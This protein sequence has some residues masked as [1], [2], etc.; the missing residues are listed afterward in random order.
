[1][2]GYF[3]L[4]IIHKILTWTTGSFH[5]HI[6]DL[7]ACEY[8]CKLQH[9]II[10]SSK[11]FCSVSTEF[12]SWEISELAHSLAHSSHPSLWWPHMIVLNFG[13]SGASA[14]TLYY[15]LS[16]DW[17]LFFVSLIVCVCVCVCVCRL[18]RR[19]Q[20]E[21]T[22]RCDPRLH[23]FSITNQCWTSTTSTNQQQVM[24]FPTFFAP[25][26]FFLNYCLCLNHGLNLSF[27][28]GQLIKWQ[29]HYFLLQI[30]EMCNFCHLTLRLAMGAML[31]VVR[32]RGT[33]QKWLFSSLQ[34]R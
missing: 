9:I 33:G 28:W 13:F 26:A 10:A 7:Y 20:G 4:S 14:L 30:T 19:T 12:D 2:L 32:L 5:V 27:I 8:T 34:R 11:G 25:D 3:V 21:S 24:L 6:Y 18:S 16:S 22:Q 15:Q 17:V 31:A 29:L 23:A 1:M